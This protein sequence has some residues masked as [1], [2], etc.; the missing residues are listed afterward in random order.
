M[1]QKAGKAAN[2]SYVV[3][4]KS[5]AKISAVERILV[6]STMEDQFRSFEKKGLSAPERRRI[7]SEK[8]GKVR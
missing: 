3:G 2:A 5:F 7:L 8:Y 1:R 4:R 6:S